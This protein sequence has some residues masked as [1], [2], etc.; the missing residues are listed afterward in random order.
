MLSLPL[1]SITPMSSFPP[2]PPLWSHTFQIIPS[3]THSLKELWGLWMALIFLL[4]LLLL[5]M[6][7]ITTAKVGPHRMSLR[8]LHSTYT[9]ATSSVV[10]REVLLIGGSFMMHACMTWSFQLAGITLQ[11]PAIPS[12]MHLWCH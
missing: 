9:F 5:N 3:S 2:K 8:Q 7:A 1:L 6:H 11:M 4:I 12:V 10:G